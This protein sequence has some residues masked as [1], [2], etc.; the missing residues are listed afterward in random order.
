MRSGLTVELSQPLLEKPPFWLLACELE[1][2]FVGG[3]RFSRPSQ[4]TAQVGSRGVSQMVVRQFTTSQDVVDDRESGRR[5]VAHRN[6]GGTIQFDDWRRVDLELQ[7]VQ[8]NNLG[9][10]GRGR[11]LRFGM[12]G[13]DR[14]L[15]RV[16]PESMRTQ[17]L[18]DEGRAF[19]DLPT[20]PARSV[21][22]RKQDELPV[23]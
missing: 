16:R 2:P 6:R 14:C 19:L 20:I 17:S 11:V 4:T 23:R 12:D 22:I 15:K 5:S 1:R 13:R 9:P 8:R 18:R 21:L 3:A 7:I 10:V